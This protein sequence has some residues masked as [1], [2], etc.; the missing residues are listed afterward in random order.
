MLCWACLGAVEGR[1]CEEIPNSNIEIRN[2]SELPNIKGSKQV[3][4]AIRKAEAWLEGFAGGLGAGDLALAVE[5]KYGRDRTFSVPILTMCAL[6]G[7]LGD[8]REAWKLIKALP[9]ELAVFPHR[10]YHLLRL[11]VVSYALPALIAIGQVH[12]HYRKPWNPFT[13]IVRKLAREKTLEVLERIQP[14]NGGFLEAAPLTG[15]VVMS[16]A[17]A[18]LRDNLVCRRGVEFLVNSVREDGSWPIDTNLSTWVTSLSVNGLAA[19]DDFA[20]LLDADAREKILKM[21]LDSQYKERH[22]YTYAAPGGWAWTALPGAVPDADDTAGAL[23]AFKNLAPDD[24]R[25]IAAASA[26]IEWLLGLQNSDGGIPTFCR[27]WTKLPFDRSAPDLTAHALGAF[28]AWADSVSASL[29]GRIERATAEGLGYL[30]SAQK[31]CGAW[32]PLWFGNEEAEDQENPVYGTARVLLGLFRLDSQWYGDYEAMAGRAV[33]W[34][35]SV[36]NADGGWGGDKGVESS[37]EETALAMNALAEAAAWAQAHTAVKSEI[38]STKSETISKSESS[39][40]PNK[41]GAKHRTLQ[42]AVVKGAQWLLENAEGD[43]MTASPIGL[44]FAKL[45]YYEELYPLVFAVSAL[46]KVMRVKSEILSTKS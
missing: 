32:V 45:W 27:G 16:L 19:G 9:F 40:D 33:E 5:R 34:L 17:M 8:S 44:Y 43:S 23:I 30:Q 26:G 24:E 28:G 37:I 10:F 6:A 3:G 14:E 1:G 41:D 29:H 35:V 31:A 21:L 20:E 46:Q 25:A 18:G 38:L 13:R 7:R 36:Q 42:E 39:N 15:F 2:K 22:P 4:E 12:Y 11:P